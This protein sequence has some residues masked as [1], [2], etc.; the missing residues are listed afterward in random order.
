MTEP[1]GDQEGPA[2]LARR[3]PLA[4][5]ERY[6]AALAGLA[7]VGLTAVVL[8]PLAIWTGAGPGEVV[9]ATLVYGGLL[10]LASGFVYVDWVHARQCPRCTVR[11][12]RGAERCDAC[13]HD[14]TDAARYLCERRHRVYVEPGLCDC[15]RRLD[16]VEVARGLGREL[17]FSLKVAGWL[18]AFLAGMALLLNLLG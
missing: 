3:A 11:N 1:P 17:V 2:V 9:A 12:P 14:L 4:P 15:G 5:R 10:G 16:R 7:P 13:A 8:T 18:I 6:R